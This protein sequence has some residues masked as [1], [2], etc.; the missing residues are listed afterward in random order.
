[1]IAPA[2]RPASLAAARPIFGTTDIAWMVLGWAVWIV[3]NFTLVAAVLTTERSFY[4]NFVDDFRHE[5]STTFGVLAIS[6]L[7][8][9]VGAHFWLLLPLLMIPMVILYQTGQ[10]A[11]AS[12]YAA[13]HDALTGLP[14]RVTLGFELDRAFVEHERTAVPF[15]LMLLDLDDFKRVNDTLGHQV[16]DELLVR[17]AERLRAATNPRDCIARLGGD[18]FAML[19]FGADSERAVEIAERLHAELSADV[20]IGSINLEVSVS[21]GIAL[22]PEHGLDGTTLLQRADVAM[23]SA[24]DRRR[25]VDTYSPS[26]DENSPDQLELVGQ[27][28]QA[29]RD[30]DIELHYQ[31]KLDAVNSAPIG[32]EALVRWRHPT[33]GY[34]EPERFIALAERSGVMSE[35]T[36]RVIELA[37]EQS[38]RWRTLGVELPIAVNV[39]PTDLIGTAFVTL[40]SSLLLRYEVDPSMLVL[41]ITERMATDQIEEVRLTLDE[42]RARGVRISLDDFG[43]GYSS[44]LRLSSL[45]VD[46][47][48]I[49][50]AF[51]AAM[52]EGDGGVS[53]V[54]TIIELAHGRGMI[55]IAEGVEHPEQWRVLAAL[56]CDGIQGWHVAR[57]MPTEQTTAWVNSRLAQGPPARLPSVAGVAPVHAPE[58]GPSI[59][60]V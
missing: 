22:C 36:A 25:A 13:G 31:P 3:V 29:L 18:E 35:L 28:R 59:S 4:D 38:L 30:G 6:P 11:T 42:L 39:S 24:K 50:R 51:V 55:A 27:L 56:G 2:F 14:N 52:S 37:L 60:R 58:G 47:I 54:R 8:V 46:E 41:E 34:I 20:V 44:L 57:P 32:F 53:I 7:V 26:R 1:M 9:I 5:T 16:G 33:Q 10:I 49:D 17:F 21:L 45:N 15:A 43:T 19:V 23:Y 12:E 40:V 48:K